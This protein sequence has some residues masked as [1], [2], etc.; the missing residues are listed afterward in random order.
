[1]PPPQWWSLR[2]EVYTAAR[3]VVPYG[4]VADF[5]L[6]YRRPNTG[7]LSRTRWVV[8][9]EMLGPTLLWYEDTSGDSAI[10]FRLIGRNDI[11][12]V[13]DDLTLPMPWIELRDLMAAVLGK[14]AL[15]M[16][17]VEIP[18]AG[19]GTMVFTPQ[20]IQ[21]SRSGYDDVREPYTDHV[22]GWTFTAEP[23]DPVE[24]AVWI[25]PDGQTT[26][27]KVSRCVDSSFTP[28][29]DPAEPAPAFE[30]L[31]PPPGSAP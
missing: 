11:Q 31:P 23:D 6:I 13:R 7:A 22:Y 29:S 1:M 14:Q 20:E 16:G 15:G 18:L 3:T 12:Q 5:H 24:P 17:A 26:G 27:V 21:Y 30:P 9:A 8:D 10:R 2:D 4:P 19:H 28:W 25:V